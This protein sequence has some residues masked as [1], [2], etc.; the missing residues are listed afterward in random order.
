M[1]F[2]KGMYNEKGA[3]SI[4]EPYMYLTSTKWFL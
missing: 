2:I 1:H 4:Y 3:G